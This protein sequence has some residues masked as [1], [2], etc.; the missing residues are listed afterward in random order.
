MFV[1]ALKCNFLLTHLSIVNQRTITSDLND[2]HTT[3]QDI[4]SACQ[5]MPATAEDRFA[6]VMSVSFTIAKERYRALRNVGE[7]KFSRNILELLCPLTPVCLELPGKQSSSSPVSGVP[8]TE[9]YGRIQQN[10][11]FLWRRQQSYQH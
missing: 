8:A 9:S 11:L 2:F 3:I 10:C 5:K 4:R 7:N 1:T 6:V